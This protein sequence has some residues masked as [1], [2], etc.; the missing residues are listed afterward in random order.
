MEEA[1]EPVPVAGQ[2]RLVE[3]EL[4]VQ[5]L[6]GCVVGERPENG[7]PG[8]S[9]QD[10]G[11]D[12]HDDAQ[13]PEGYEGEREAAGKKSEHLCPRW[14]PGSRRA[15]GSRFYAFVARSTNRWLMA[16]GTTP[17]TFFRVGVRML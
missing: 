5:L 8:V 3:A 7:P 13:E 16:V 17:D 10:L 11:A 4:V 2:E 14:V 9:R 12:E 15:P 6:D 1:R